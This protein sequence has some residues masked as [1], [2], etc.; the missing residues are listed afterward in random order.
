MERLARKSLKRVEA[1]RPGQPKPGQGQAAG[2]AGRA[3]GAS[4]D[5]V[6]VVR[7]RSSRRSWLGLSQFCGPVAF[8][9]RAYQR[10]RHGREAE[11]QRI[12]ACNLVV[13]LWLST[14]HLYRI[15][16]VARTPESRT[17]VPRRSDQAVLRI[18]TAVRGSF[19]QR[20]A[21]CRKRISYRAP[22]A[23]LL[24]GSLRSLFSAGCRVGVYAAAPAEYES[25]S[26][27]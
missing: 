18:A 2:F 20:P 25:N 4:L 8:C 6:P 5:R 22:G 23:L 10:L 21:R 26:S 24:S 19:A 12:P 11:L 27:S 14:C 3:V 1:K 13:Q 15:V 7:Q 9:D 16:Y 17:L